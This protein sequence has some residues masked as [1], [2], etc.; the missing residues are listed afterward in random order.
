MKGVSV[1]FLLLL[2]I[3]AVTAGNKHMM[4]DAKLCKKSSFPTNECIAMNCDSDCKEIYGSKARGVC[5]G[6]L[7]CNCFLPC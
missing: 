6:F 2:L 3:F 7:F 1:I 5:N 4:V